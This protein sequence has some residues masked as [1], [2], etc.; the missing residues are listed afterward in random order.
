[1]IQEPLFPSYVFVQSLPENLYLIKQVSS[2]IVNFVY[3]LGKP[4]TVREEEIQLIQHFLQE[5]SNV[6]L[7]KNT[8]QTNDL[9]RIMDGALKNREAN[10]I[11]IE[12][13]KVKVIIPS[14]GYKMVAETALSN[15]APMEAY[16]AKQLVS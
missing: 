5:Y 13:N 8:I 16:Q 10:V 1:M 12:H 11:A 4:A 14:L 9:V 3:W 6:K 7:E 15:I 2:D